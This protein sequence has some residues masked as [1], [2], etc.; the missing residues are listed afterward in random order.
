MKSIFASIVFI[1]LSFLVSSVGW[2]FEPQWMQFPEQGLVVK[3]Q[4][5]TEPGTG[6]DSQ[7]LLET[8]DLQ[9]GQPVAINQKLQVKLWMPSMN[10]GSAPTQIQ[11]WVET[12]GTVSITKYLIKNVYFTMGGQWQVLVTIDPKTP[13]ESTRGFEIAI[14]GGGHHGH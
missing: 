12:D 4:F 10:H 5:L 14:S 1:L 8:F 7:A 13:Q 6:K 11:R 2:S 3:F 9:S